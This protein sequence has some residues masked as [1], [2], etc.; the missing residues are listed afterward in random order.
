VKGL[1]ARGAF[2]VTM[3]WKNE[4]LTTAV[5]TSMHGGS[6]TLQTSQR[7]VVRG[8]KTTGKK[9]PGGYVTTFETVKG[10]KYTVAA[11]N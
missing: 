1:R 3:N 5:I 10:G 6:C 7:V 8:A 4:L 9:T 2:E 11:V